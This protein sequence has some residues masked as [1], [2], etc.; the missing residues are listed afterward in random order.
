M[1]VYIHKLGCPKNDVDADYIA[2]RLVDAGHQPVNNPDQADTVIVNTCGFILP[3]K[4]ESINAIL[5]FGQKKQA[6]KIR[7]LYATGCL[8]QRYGKEMLKD[9]PE[10]DGAFG[11]GALDSLAETVTARTHHDSVVAIE[12]RKL[13]YLTWKHRLITDSLP[14]SYL[15]ISDGCDRGCTYCAIP[16]MR[17]RYRSRPLDS[18]LREAQFLA[19]NGKK[20][21]ILVSQEATLWGYGLD[22]NSN[23]ITLLSELE[24]IRGVEWIRLMYLYPPEL[25]DDLIAYL[26][27]GTK[28][29]PYFDLP[30]QHVNSELLARMRRRTDRKRVE[31]LVD[32][33]RDKCSDAV[34]RTTFIV[35][36]PGETDEQ[37][38]ELV[39]FAEETRFERMGVFAYSAEE[40]TPA[41]EYENQTPEEVKHERL[42]RLMSLQREITFDLNAE[43]IGR[44]MSV[45]VD[46]VNEDGSVTGRSYADC[47][48]IDLDVVI[49]DSSLSV[50]DMM[51]VTITR[52]D[53]YDLFAQAS[54]RIKESA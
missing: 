21:L 35:G 6:G 44:S 5:E 27:S 23:V 41:A 52:S 8:T 25:S 32:T 30:F 37:F 20:E 42:D 11:H 26:G 38:E 47:P 14:Y 9:I 43:L 51:S 10:L 48:D 13:G 4:E 28:A 15:K 22:G 31:Y 2:A 12:P 53:G 29:L 16:A 24:K 45:L 49:E 36:F 46:K 7:S 34:L 17:G 3:A 1:K 39:A 50:G 18:I 19:D 33:I 40:G 54:E